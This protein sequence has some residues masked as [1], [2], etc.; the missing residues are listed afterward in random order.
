MI[1]VVRQG[2]CTASEDSML[3]NNNI[4]SGKENFLQ[5]TRVYSTQWLCNFEMIAYPFDT[6]VTYLEI[7]WHI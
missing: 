5:V 2:G 4:F 6:Q 1:T 7:G 3:D